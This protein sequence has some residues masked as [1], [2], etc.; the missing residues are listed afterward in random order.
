MGAPRATSFFPRARL[1]ELGRP[2][3]P[4][5]RSPPP[6]PSSP[7]LGGAAE[8]E[9]L[10]RHGRS[11][12]LRGG[13]RGRRT[14]RGPRPHWA[15]ATTMS[16]TWSVPRWTS[17]V[18]TAPRPRSTLASITTHPSAR[19]VGVGGQL[20]ELRLQEDRL[21]Q[22][23][24]VE[25][26][27]R[28]NLDGE[29]R[30][31]PS[32][33]SR[34]RA[35]AGPGAPGRGRRRGRSILLMAIRIGTSAARRVIDGLDGLGHDAVVGRDDEHDDIGDARAARAHLGEGGVARR[36]DE[37]DAGAPSRSRPGRRRC[38]G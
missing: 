35:A 16:P 13:G 34:S 28:R 5:A 27:G 19:A 4:G 32:P 21:L 18:A 22:P 20:Q 24:E 8:P 29:Q 14:W 36:V 9:D 37:G 6:P 33:R 23:V 17:T 7:R 25:P 12:R 3:A 1:A 26:L 31:R 38:A 2:R 10:H 11:R 15:P 30:L